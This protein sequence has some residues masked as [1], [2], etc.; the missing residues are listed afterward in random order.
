MNIL[1][2]KFES[3]KVFVPNVYRDERG[4][5]L[6]SFNRAIDVSINSKFVQDNHSSSKKYVLR[7]L[8]Y[9]WN[10]PMGKLVRVVKGRGIDVMVDIRKDSHTYGHYDMVELS[11]NNFNIVWIPPGFAHGFLSLED[12]TQLIYKTTSY[13][14]QAADGS[15]NPLCNSL[16]INWGIDHDKFIL[17]DKDKSAQTFNEYKLNPKF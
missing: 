9:Q 4:Y 12:D 7:G 3:V 17:S 14:N 1:N 16:D 15:I 11:D 8:H 6:E 13:Y 2:T 10:E 5:F